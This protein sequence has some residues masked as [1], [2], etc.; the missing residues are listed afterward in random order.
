MSEYE[1]VLQPNSRPYIKANSPGGIINEADVYGQGF[2]RVLRTAL[3][4]KQS[5]FEEPEHEQVEDIFEPDNPDDKKPLPG[6]HCD[7][8]DMVNL[9]GLDEID[10][11]HVS[12]QNKE[13]NFAVELTVAIAP[14]RR[15]SIQHR[16]DPG[17]AIRVQVQPK[18]QVTPGVVYTFYDQ[19]Q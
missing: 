18:E 3:R 9:M 5:G 14:D 10:E 4:S 16:P 19:N 8:D 12:Q 1:R 6:D 11:Q 17:A 15:K 2:K 13:D 7:D